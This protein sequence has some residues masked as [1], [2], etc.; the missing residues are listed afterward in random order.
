[1]QYSCEECLSLL[2]VFIKE[3]SWCQQ[4][5]IY[6]LFVWSDNIIDSVWTFNDGYQISWVNLLGCRFDIAAGL[7]SHGWLF[8]CQ[9]QGGFKSSLWNCL[10][11]TCLVRLYFAFLNAQMYNDHNVRP[12][13]HLCII[14]RGSEESKLL[15][16][17]RS[18]L[19]CGSISNL[20]E[21]TWNNEMAKRL[22]S[23]ENGKIQVD[24]VFPVMI[25]LFNKSLSY[26]LILSYL[27]GH[28]LS[29]RSHLILEG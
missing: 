9:L 3:I 19:D 18:S 10:L 27:E 2:G 23:Q 15:G 26:L 29:G 4:V 21:D 5:C 11:P 20:Y 16:I 8:H 17:N 12:C 28:I 13:I 14:G 1:M 6:V 22:I 24:H 25:W 7:C